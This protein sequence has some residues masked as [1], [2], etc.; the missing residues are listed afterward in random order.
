M[1]PAPA[2]QIAVRDEAGAELQ[3]P[4][5]TFQIAVGDDGASIQAREPVTSIAPIPRPKRPESVLAE[6]TYESKVHVLR[7][8]NSRR[9]GAGGF[10]GVFQADMIAPDRTTQV[11]AVKAINFLFSPENPAGTSQ[12]SEAT[13]EL[14]LREVSIWQRLQHPRILPFYGMSSVFGLEQVGLVSPLVANGDMMAFIMKNPDKDR[15]RLVQQ[16]AEGLE[17]LHQTAKLVHGDLKCSNI[18]ISDD[19]CALVA[20]FGLSTFITVFQ[21]F[22]QSCQRPSLIGRHNGLGTV[23]GGV[24]PAKTCSITLSTEAPRHGASLM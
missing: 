7:I 6:I 16:V 13:E 2:I 3:A 12:A 14:L 24:W 8:R 5:P 23:R 22:R 17:Y 20:D 15:L 18:L 10:S 1:D 21:Q 9:L 4:T 11:V 19:E